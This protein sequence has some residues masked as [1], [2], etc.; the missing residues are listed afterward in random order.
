MTVGMFILS[1]KQR[2]NLS[3]IFIILII[4]QIII[5]CGMTGSSLYIIISIAPMLKQEQTEINFVFI[6]T[7]L[8]GTNVIVH[9]V[10]GIHISQ[11]CLKNA[12]RKSTS[13]I[14]LSWTCLGTGTIIQLLITAHFARK[15]N[16]YL[17]RSI[18]Q[19]IA[20]G[21]GQYLQDVAWKENMDKLQYN[22]ECCGMIS[23]DDW[24][25][26]KWLT[27]YHVDVTSKMIKQI[28]TNGEILTFP[29]VPW[30]CCKVDFP[31]QCLHDPIQQT[32]YAHIWVDEPSIVMESINT[33]GCL[34]LIRKPITWTIN[35]FVTFVS[36]SCVVHVIIFMISRILYTSSRNAILL[37][38]PGGLAPG[39]IF[40]RGDC[41]YSGGKTLLEIMERRV[42]YVE[43]S[44]YTA[45]ETEETNKTKTSSK[46]SFKRFFKKKRVLHDASDTEKSDDESAK[47]LNNNV[48][49]DYEL[50]TDSGE[51]KTTPEVMLRKVNEIKTTSE[52][53]LKTDRNKNKKEKY[54]DKKTV[55]IY[56]EQISHSPEIKNKAEINN[57]KKIIKPDS[58]KDK[59]KTETS[60]KTSKLPINKKSKSNDTDGKKLKR[61]H[62]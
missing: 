18:K 40:G 8:C 48:Q 56:P 2:Q 4:F 57:T 24:H 9:W 1:Q 36:L 59:S 43:E 42:Q 49:R 54:P 12:S 41:G 13:S 62:E 29:V 30:S 55:E 37:G 32:E 31:L 22:N 39:W 7:G 45:T 46:F 21:M 17:Y 6:V 58:S 38:S 51:R 53:P 28:R 14:F 23:F 35:L 5:G 11:R 44:D 27:K 26:T 61:L 34:N 3:I 52:K 33:K 50:S 47:L 19:S 20:T 10:Q 60:A 25:N 15:L 16:K